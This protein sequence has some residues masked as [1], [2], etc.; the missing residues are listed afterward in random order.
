ME[1]VSLGIAMSL[2]QKIMSG[3]PSIIFKSHL[4]GLKRFHKK[5]PPAAPAIPTALSPAPEPSDPLP[6]T[7]WLRF[8]NADKKSIMA[9]C[10]RYHWMMG[11]ILVVVVQAYIYI[12]VFVQQLSDWTV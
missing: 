3:K 11:R 10:F 12:S 4:H 9:C 2:G 8:S 1:P 6:G 5:P 7:V